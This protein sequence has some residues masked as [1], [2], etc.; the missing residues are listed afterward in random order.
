MPSDQPEPKPLAFSKPQRDVRE[1]QPRASEERAVTP[2]DFGS[3]AVSVDP[4]FDSREARRR[5]SNAEPGK[6]VFGDHGH[7]LLNRSFELARQQFPELYPK[8]GPRIERGIRQLL[9]LR[10]ETI[11]MF[12]D[13]ALRTCGESV[14]IFMRVTRDFAD[15][16]AAG[17]MR[18]MLDSATRK[19]G[20]LDRLTEHYLKPQRPEMDYRESLSTLKVSLQSFMPR[21]RVLREEVD[22]AR[23]SLASGLAAL[24]AVC[25]ID[26]GGNATAALAL[27]ERRSAVR[28][29][30][31]QLEL[32]SLQV[33][34][35]EADLVGL[36]SRADQL[37]NITLPAALAARNQRS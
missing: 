17:L 7:P 28:Q 9:P 37:A 20:I 5:V 31:Q 3:N 24:S 15:L 29:A 30:F 4:L 33:N 13:A 1:L 35:F 23:E 8:H 16:D 2:L 21:V 18:Q 6:S 25:D 14:D 36:L 10:L 27:G 19:P 34:A 12:A 32:L 11:S 22:H 26:H